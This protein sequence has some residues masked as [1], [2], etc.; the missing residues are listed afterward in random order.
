MEEKREDSTMAE[1]EAFLERAL[2]IHRTAIVMNAAVMRRALQYASTF[3]IPVIQ[4][5]EDHHLTEGAQMNEGAVSTRLGL[6]GWPRVAEDIIVARDILLTADTRSRYHVA[7]ISSGGAAAMVREAKSRGLRVSAEVTPHHLL[8][9][10]EA[11]IGYDT[12][13]KVNPPLRTEEDREAMVEALAD[14][15]IDCIATD[16]A[17][18]SII[19]KDCEFQQAAVGI[20]GL[21][22]AVASL[23]KLVRDEKLSAMRFVE[24]LTIS[25]VRLFPALDGGVIAEDARADL[26]VID[27]EE[28][29]TVRADALY[30]KSHN[31]PLLDK[32]LCGRVEMTIAAGR[33]I[34]RRES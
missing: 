32:E 1:R 12:H 5:C 8:L 24:S 9:T 17:P 4:H 6:R 15:T 25:P 33:V 29:W 22:S 28:R 10:D 7:H 30:S 2:S 23:L 27:P 34:Y 11:V 31:T 20:N 26:V 18:H 19:E 14:G 16:H 13:C 3:D 21:E